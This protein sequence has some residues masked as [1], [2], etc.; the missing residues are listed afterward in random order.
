MAYS[1]A[2]PLT[3]L[4]PHSPRFSPVHWQR[5]VCGGGVGGTVSVW[6]QYAKHEAEAAAGLGLAHVEQN[7]AAEVFGILPHR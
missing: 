3:Y 1:P 7:V 6:G 4:W 2:L 5:Y